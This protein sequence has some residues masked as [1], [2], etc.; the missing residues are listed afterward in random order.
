MRRAR[1]AHPAAR[2]S[3]RRGPP[4]DL[5]PRICRAWNYRARC[6][7]ADR[8]CPSGD[9]VV[10]GGCGGTAG[11]PAAG[12]TGRPGPGPDADPA[13]AAARDCVPGRACHDRAITP[14]RG[15]GAIPGPAS[16]HV[17]SSGVMQRAV[18]DTRHQEVHSP[19]ASEAC[20]RL[21]P[22]GR[23]VP[24]DHPRA[25]GGRYPARCAPGSSS[26]SGSPHRPSA[27]RCAA[28]SVTATS[29]CDRFAAITLTAAGRDYATSIMRR[30]RLAERLL[31]DV[32]KVPWSQV[33]EEAGRLEHAISPWL[34]EH[35]VPSS[36]TR[37]PART[38]TRSPARRTRPTSAIS[39]PFPTCPT[40][41]MWSS[42]GSMSSSKASTLSM[43]TL[44]T[45]AVLPGRAITIV[46]RGA[47]R[48][49]LICRRA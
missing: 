35:L 41:S 36:A 14:H 44:E 31:V 22:S 48:M 5:P 42:G 34:E 2:G 47:E 16:E 1:N 25:G 23:G 49:Q 18:R 11:R 15:H 10:T 29:R 26:A 7:P 30:H 39:G 19:V 32:L 37:R 45:E 17:P 21:S 33:H 24:G 43:Q 8:D 20:P 38:A 40:G 3:P 4:P 9:K 13:N 46:G 6:R 28:S 27:R 12:E